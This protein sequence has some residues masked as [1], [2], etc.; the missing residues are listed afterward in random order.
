MLAYTLASML[1]PAE[2]AKSGTEH[3]HQAALCQWVAVEGC[4]Q[5]PGLELLF[6]IPNGG[7]RKPS[8]AAQLKAEGVKPGVPDMMLPLPV[9]KY[10]GLFLEMK[11]PNGYVRDDQDEWHRKLRN[12][13]YAVVVAFDWVSAARILIDYYRGVQLPLPEDGTALKISTPAGLRVI[14]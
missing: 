3:G 14:N 12:C 11:R 5:Y 6:A 8:V 4:K 10:P 2:I 1:T 7:D 9:G 13:G